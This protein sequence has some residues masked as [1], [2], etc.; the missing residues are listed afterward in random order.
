[1]FRKYTP[2]R[3]QEAITLSLTTMI[4]MQCNGQKRCIQHIGGG[5]GKGK[6]G[7]AGREGEEKEEVVVIIGGSIGHLPKSTFL[8]L[9]NAI[10]N[11]KKY[12]WC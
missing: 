5:R 4:E 10:R 8:L 2:G 1:M 6:G 12:F 7:E 3:Y 9:Q 11:D